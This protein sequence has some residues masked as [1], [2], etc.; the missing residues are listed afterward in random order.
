MWCCTVCEWNDDDKRE[1][2]NV[3][4]YC[5]LCARYCAYGLAPKPV[6]CIVACG[7]CICCANIGI[8]VA[9]LITFAVR[10]PERKVM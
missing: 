9:L 5:W 8:M 2:E 6:P 10:V 3:P 7:C 4:M 1:R